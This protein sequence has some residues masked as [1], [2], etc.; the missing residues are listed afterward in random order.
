MALFTV[1]MLE[2]A[3][4]FQDEHIFIHP[5]KWTMVKVLYLTCRYYPLLGWPFYLWT[6]IQNHSIK[7]CA[8]MV[9]AIYAL[10]IPLPISAQAVIAIR[11]IAFTERQKRVLFVVYPFFFVLAVA[12]AWTFTVDIREATSFFYPYLGDTECIRMQS[13]SAL[14]NYVAKRTGYILL[15]SFIFDLLCI[16]MVGIH[17]WRN[18]SLRGRLLTTFIEQGITGFFIMSAVNLLAMAEYFK[19]IK[20]DHGIGMEFAFTLNNI[21]ACRLIL[22]LRRFSLPTPTEIDRAHSVI[23]RDALDQD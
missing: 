9:H 2:W 13:F 15:A 18:Y 3:L 7:A 17:C 14:G 10:L 20:E 16:T 6:I 5:T 23:V 1:Q 8:S 4:T 22:N 21:V 19:P 12:Q 11:T